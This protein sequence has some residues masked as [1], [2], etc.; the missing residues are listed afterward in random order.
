MDPN[1]EQNDPHW[2]GNPYT[3]ISQEEE[4][5]SEGCSIDNPIIAFTEDLADDG[6]I[7]NSTCKSDD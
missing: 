5:R 7:N 6:I 2:S 4:Q 1:I 3:P